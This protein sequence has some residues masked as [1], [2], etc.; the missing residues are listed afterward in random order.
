VVAGE[1]GASDGLT[2]DMGNAIALDVY[3]GPVEWKSM[4][5]VD[6]QLG[7]MLFAGLWTPFRWLA[8]ALFFL[9]AFI[10]RWVPNAGLAIIALSLCVKILLFPLTRIADRWQSDVNRIQSRV[11]PKLAAIRR[12]FRGEDAH[13][14]TL[15]AYAEESVSPWF[16]LKSLGGFAIQVPMFIAAFDMLAGN[17]A[18]SGASFLW[19]RD[20]ARPDAFAALP[21]TLPFFGGDLN[22][23]PCLMTLITLASAVVQRE[24]SLSPELQ[25]RQRRQLFLMA[26]LFFLLFYTFPAGMVLYWTANNGWHLLKI[27]LTQPKLA[28]A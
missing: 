8:F 22:L 13:R 16:T 24:A 15:A 11:V 3:A 14:R 20:L 2:W 17:F 7:T 5:I 18:L 25:S 9:L 1:A 23:L 27:L 26:G 6:P 10:S 12:E 4:R 19:V 28:T 21:I